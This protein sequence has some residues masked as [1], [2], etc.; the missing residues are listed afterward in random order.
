MAELD[1]CVING[2]ERADVKSGDVVAIIGAGPMWLVRMQLAKHGGAG[3]IIVGDLVE[4][5]LKI[6]KRLE[7][8]NAGQAREKNFVEGMKE[9][10][11]GRLAGLVWRS[12]ATLDRPRSW[13][14]SI[15][16]DL[17]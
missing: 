10:T 7:G 5:R 14:Y 17:H 16:K 11:D 1:S 8:R 9:A 12:S 6:A 4:K 15:P 3:W 13:A 2:V